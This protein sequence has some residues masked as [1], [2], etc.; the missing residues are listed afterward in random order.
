MKILVGYDG[1][2]PSKAAVELALKHAA[3]FGAEIVVCNSV[4][5]PDPIEEK[6]ASEMLADV[7][8]KHQNE[9]VTLTTHLA[10]QGLSPG[11]DLVKY[12]QINDIDEIIIGIKK[13]SKIGKL[14][15]GSNAQYVLLNA[16]CPV[17]AVKP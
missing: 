2:E 12:A 17:V 13:V 4:M 14:L 9:S 5:V 1:S 8:K 6:R 7:Q 3:A 11:E 10:L 16:A 15:F